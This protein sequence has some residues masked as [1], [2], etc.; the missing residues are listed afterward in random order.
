MIIASI[1]P[2]G[3]NHKG[4]PHGMGPGGRFGGGLDLELKAHLPQDCLRFG[5]GI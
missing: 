3:R 2:E 5:S 1:Q 4:F